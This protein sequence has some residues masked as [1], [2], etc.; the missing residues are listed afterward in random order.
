MRNDEV[1]GRIADPDFQTELGQFNIEINI[2]PAARRARTSS[3]L[4]RDVR[5]ASTRPTTSPTTPAPT[6]S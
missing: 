3:G 5:A 2:P 6:W 1:L 4:E